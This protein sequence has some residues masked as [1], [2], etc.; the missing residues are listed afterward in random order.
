MSNQ[1]RVVL[2]GQRNRHGDLEPARPEQLKQS[3]R[4]PP[5]G[6]EAR[7]EDVAVQDSPHFVMVSHTIP[8]WRLLVQAG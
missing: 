7:H 4:R 8:M 6:S 2:Q 3:E 5:S 1:L